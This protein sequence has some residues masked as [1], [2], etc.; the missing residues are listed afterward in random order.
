[1]SKPNYDNI[2]NYLSNLAP[3]S[4]GGPISNIE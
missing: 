4:V 3:K 1:M 2:T